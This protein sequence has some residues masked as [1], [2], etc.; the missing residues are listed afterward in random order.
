MGEKCKLPLALASNMANDELVETSCDSEDAATG[1][2][3]GEE[4]I[5]RKT[6]SETELNCKACGDTRLCMP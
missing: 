3:Q 6:G 5:K 1:D 4:N 2:K